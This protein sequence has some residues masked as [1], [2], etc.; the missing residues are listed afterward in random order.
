MKHKNN[1]PSDVIHLTK[2]FRKENFEIFLVGGCVRDLIMGT[3]PHDYDMCTNA[4]PDQMKELC[5]KYRLSCIPTGLQ[6]GT[7]T[8]RLNHESYEIT[9]YRVD[10]AYSDGRHPDKV[11]FTDNLRE[12]L[13]RRDFTI[14]AIAMDPI[15]CKLYDPFGGCLDIAQKKLRAV[16]HADARLS[17][18]GLRIL[19]ALRFAI[20]YDL[21]ID[22][23]LE[24]AIHSHK[25]MLLLTSNLISR[26]R[27]TD[28]FRKIFTTGKPVSEIFMQFRDVIAAVI[29]EI[30]KTFDFDQNN[31]YHKH[32]VYEHLLAVT[33][34]CKSNKF[35]IRMAAL[36]HDIGK[37]DAYVTDELGRGHF[38]GHP[39]ISANIC[40]PMLHRQFK[41]SNEEYSRI[42][43]LIEFHD[44]DVKETTKSVK[45]V[46]NKHGVDFMTDWFV[47]KQA[48]MDDHIYPDDKY[49]T[50]TRNMKAIADEIINSMQ[51]FTIKDL[52]VNGKDLM[53]E[54][55]LKPGKTIGIILDK[56]LEEVIEETLENNKESLLAKADEIRERITK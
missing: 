50:T 3:E 47:L 19:R 28:E 34:Y 21:M 2:I 41:L 15:T 43:E 51:A 56:L 18:D 45:R 38:Y 8:V 35:E 4:T 44:A 27:I 33:D 12:D 54:L 36:L 5:R 48:D 40:R 17:E 30:Q 1:I 20:K 6:H 23:E 42:V 16:G 46:L 22:D 39:E 26:E 55:G 29:P 24:N 37:P 53:D 52:A 11:A 31:R 32:D 25:D 13:L 14:N 7:I 10:G 49:I 9:T